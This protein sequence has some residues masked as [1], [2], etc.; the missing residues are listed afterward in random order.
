MKL[1]FNHRVVVLRQMRVKPSVQDDTIQD[2]SPDGRV[3][4]VII[5]PLLNLADGSLLSAWVC[6][7]HDAFCRQ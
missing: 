6:D 4:I 2:L 5:W 3:C 1:T 7:A